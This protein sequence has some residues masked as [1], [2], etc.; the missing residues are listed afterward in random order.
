MITNEQ[1]LL[2][3]N[4][5]ERLRRDN[6]RLRRNAKKKAAYIER[7]NRAYSDAIH[8]CVHM[9]NGQGIRPTRKYCAE[10]LGIGRRRWQAAIALLRIARLFGGRRWVETTDQM[11]ADRLA[12]ARQTALD[13]PQAFYSRL[14]RHGRDE[15]KRRER[16][17]DC[18]ASA[19]KM[20]VRQ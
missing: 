5:V 16:N 13:T 14:S 8:L 4:E 2:L 7:I 11:A 12:T 10:R 1:I 3:Q 9:A 20:R 18:N 15:W 6:L 19:V 17:K